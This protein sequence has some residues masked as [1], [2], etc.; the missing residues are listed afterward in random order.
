MFPDFVPAPYPFIAATDSKY[1]YKVCDNVF[2]FTP[3]EVTPEDQ[4]RIH[5]L[6]ERCKIDDLEK[7]TQFFARLFENTCFQFKKI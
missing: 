6:N 7:A 5:A 3:F 1:Y 2:R 4:H